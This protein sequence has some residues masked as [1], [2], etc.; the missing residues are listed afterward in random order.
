MPIPEGV[1]I[2]SHSLV[3]ISELPVLSISHHILYFS[4]AFYMNT[5]SLD[6]IVNPLPLR[7]NK[8]MA[9]IHQQETPL[10][11]QEKLDG[12]DVKVAEIEPELPEAHFDR[13][14]MRSPL[15]RPRDVS[16]AFSARSSF[17]SSR[18]RVRHSHGHSYG[19]AEWRHGHHR[20]EVS[21]E[22]KLQA[23]SE[24]SGLIELMAS[25]SRR[26]SSL[27]EIWLRYESEIDACYAEMD[28]MQ[29]SIEEY[30]EIVERTERESHTHTHEHE[31][32]K[33]EITKLKLEITAALT[34]TAEYKKKLSDRDCELADIKIELAE[35][36]DVYKYLKEEHESTKST[37][38]E[39]TSLLIAA[40][41]RCKHAEDDARRHECELHD[42]KESY[43]ELEEKHS[44]TVS[45]YEST[46]TEYHSIKKSFDVLKKKEEEWQHE[47]AELHEDVRKC[48]HRHEETKR[49]LKEMQEHYE[50]FEK[51]HSETVEKKEREIRELHETSSKLRIEKKELEERIK[52]I[53]RDYDDEHCKWEDAEDRCGKWKLKWEHS[54]REIV[55]IREEL[56]VI[57][58][59][60]TELR[61]TVT[62]KTEEITKLKRSC[63][64]FERDYHSKCKELSQCHSD[65]LVAK[66]T[67]RRHESTIKEKSEE[68]HTLSERVE[69]LHSECDSHRGRCENYAAEATSLEALIVSLRLEISTA[70]SEHEST[71]KKLHECETRYH[72]VCET[73]EEYQE[74]NSGHEY[75]ISKLHSMLR[76]VREEKERAITARIAADHD[77]DDAVVRLE[78]KNREFQELFAE[79]ERF[80]SHTG[81]RT[82]GRKLRRFVTTTNGECSSGDFEESASVA[83]G[84]ID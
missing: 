45:K 30:T 36:R 50:R 22:I 37:L 73:Y 57:E 52:V 46:K 33:A 15:A 67:I 53:T 61:E 78:A 18:R 7:A 39:T 40:E 21:R 68:I 41:K 10:S 9:S 20:S 75:Q 2:S 47:R 28:R 27:R 1:Y 44:E 34:S 62:K 83:C 4:I 3:P 65:L 25:V 31:E 5:Q 70:S 71:L 63:E 12:I 51:E 26:S 79:M 38:E 69:R 43:S 24:F 84:E 13:L 72:E 49:K 23:E 48:N 82:G 8:N 55:S 42:L 81:G 77:R 58:I 74:G 56:R 32:R 19:S 80:S 16:P 59:K 11:F 64:H 17:S 35:A 6:A 76:E 60:Q 54:E 66:E 14:T 29:C